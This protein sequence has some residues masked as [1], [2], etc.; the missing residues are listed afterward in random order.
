[1]ESRGL[2]TPL[3]KQYLTKKEPERR[4]RKGLH[5]Q[6]STDNIFGHT[7]LSKKL[8]SIVAS[9]R[10]KLF[11][12]EAEISSNA[13]PADSK[14]PQ[15]ETSHSDEEVEEHEDELGITYQFG[16]NGEARSVGRRCVEE[17]RD[18]A[19]FGNKEYRSRLEQCLGYSES[20]EKL[21][22]MVD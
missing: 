6:R 2:Q 3:S 10:P 17:S 21:R 4:H 18:R 5:G 12:A 20:N 9:E 7:R 1:M 19:F 15:A 8:G 22:P 11:A 14:K 16:F 13:R